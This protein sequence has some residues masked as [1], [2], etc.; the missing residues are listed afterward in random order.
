M[1]YTPEHHVSNGYVITEHPCVGGNTIFGLIWIGHPGSE[2]A[3]F[4]TAE[5]AEAFAERAVLENYKIKMGY[6][7]SIWK[8]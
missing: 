7:K 6:K 8:Q 3:G 1:K 5:Q 4:Q 2:S